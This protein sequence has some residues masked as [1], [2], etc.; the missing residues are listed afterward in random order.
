MRLMTSPIFRTPEY[1]EPTRPHAIPDY[2]EPT[3][4]F[5][6]NESSTWTNDESYGS[7]H[8]DEKHMDEK[9]ESKE[10][11]VLTDTDYLP[12]YK[13]HRYLLDWFLEGIQT[14]PTFPECHFDDSCI[15]IGGNLNE[16][17]K[18]EFFGE[19]T[20]TE[21]VAIAD[22]QKAKATKKYT[23][24]L[25]VY[26]FNSDID[27]MVAEI[28]ELQHFKKFKNGINLVVVTISMFSD[29]QQ[30][31]KFIEEVAEHGVLNVEFVDGNRPAIISS[32]T[33]VLEERISQHLKQIRTKL[34]TYR[35]PTSTIKTKLLKLWCP[36]SAIRSSLVE[37]NAILRRLKQA[38]SY[39]ESFIENEEDR[40]DKK[41]INKILQSF[42][43]RILYD[44]YDEEI[45]YIITTDQRV[46]KALEAWYSSSDMHDLKLVI[47]VEENLSLTELSKTG[48]PLHGAKLVYMIES[49]ESFNK[50][51]RFATTGS[52]MFANNNNMMI[53]V[54][55]RHSLEQVDTCFTLIDNVVV[56]LGK[57]MPQPNN[58][59]E[60]LC[61]DIAVV[62]IDADT[63]S[64]VD[65]KCEKLL[66]DSFGFP[67]PAQISFR[68]LNVG[69]IVH[70]RGA[71]TGFTTGI[72]KSIRNQAIGR[73]RLPSTVIF[74]ASRDAA[75]FAMGGDSGS[76]VFQP[77]LSPEETGLEVLAMVHG[78][79]DQNFQTRVVC[80]PF[81]ESCDKLKQNIPDLQNLQFFNS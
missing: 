71:K 73:F 50:D 9:Q 41:E 7:E 64:V 23:N 36:N 34:L 81:K 26:I 20:L 72:V 25:M 78:K 77:S 48:V 80:L 27:E 56:R 15:I 60:R 38:S 10:F 4:V 69:D 30:K 32:L 22:L 70:K 59:M 29:E 45:L 42:G 47:T 55:C 3:V 31:S 63:R 68:D 49:V 75:A 39:P 52:L 6:T 53:V 51:N 65:E 46:K 14:L 28:I 17:N 43:D 33:C 54:T 62:A 1:T 19:T 13:Y 18:I 12:R 58:R 5:F 8:M 2:D 21:T 16:K 76:L 44:E 74:I 79:I 67:S 24:V 57:E 11:L 40:T 37:V 35:S 66:I 61:D